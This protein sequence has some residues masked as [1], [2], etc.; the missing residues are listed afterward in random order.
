MRNIKNKSFKKRNIKDILKRL[1][2]AFSIPTLMGTLAACGST[3][4]VTSEPTTSASTDANTENTTASEEVTT[5]A[6]EKVTTEKATEASTQAPIVVSDTLDIN[7]NVSIENTVDKIYLDNKTFFD[8]SGMSKDDIRAMILVINDKFTNEDGTP[9]INPEIMNRGFDGINIV[10]YSDGFIQKM[11]NVNTVDYDV[12]KFELE[13]QPS[14]VDFIDVNISGGAVLA[15]EVKEYEKLRDYEVDYMNKE[16]KLDVEAINQAVIKNEVTD[17]N[18]NSNP[19][20]S[21][22]GIG[23]QYL[24]ASTHLYRLNMAAVANNYDG[25]YLRAPEYDGINTVKINY[26]SGERDVIGAVE[27]LIIDGLLPEETYNNVVT[28]IKKE[29]ELNK[30]DKEIIEA[31][32]A[33]YEIKMD[34]RNLILADVKARMSMASTSYLDV[35]CSRYKEFDDKVLSLSN[36]NTLKL[37]P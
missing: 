8:Q 23:Q 30:S 18:E 7:D 36:S 11:D 25:I 6:T 5:D 20:S 10:L 34:Y 15:D 21:V 17:I 19:M 9:A 1:A 31:V 4:D 28:I 37:Q 3:K 14:L 27:R 13:K 33:E 16:G 12:D 2:V 35:Q 26:T 24:M 29:L 32:G 22:R